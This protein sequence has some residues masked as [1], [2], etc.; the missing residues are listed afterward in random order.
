M[1]KSKNLTFYC[2]LTF[3]L[4]P[5]RLKQMNRVFLSSQF[6]VELDNDGDKLHLFHKVRADD[7]DTGG[8]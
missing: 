6:L 7:V 3:G 2:Q 5:C 1:N 8:P 4:K